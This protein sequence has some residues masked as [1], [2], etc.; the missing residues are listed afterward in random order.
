LGVSYKFGDFITYAVLDDPDDDP[1]HKQYLEHQKLKRSSNNTNPSCSYLNGKLSHCIG[2]F[3]DRSADDLRRFFQERG[4]FSVIGK[5][6]GFI[7]TNGRDMKSIKH[8]RYIFPLT[9]F[10]F[11]LLITPDRHSAGCIPAN[12]DASLKSMLLYDPFLKG[13]NCIKAAV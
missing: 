10:L 1:L 9:A 4:I 3:N 11:H 12:L 6:A 7:D 5:F 2:L 13:I 8:Y